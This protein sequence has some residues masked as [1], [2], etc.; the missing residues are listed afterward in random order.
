M[1]SG[2]GYDAMTVQVWTDNGDFP[3]GDSKAYTR[4]AQ[5]RSASTAPSTAPDSGGGGGGGGS[6]SLL[7]LL[8]LAL[9]AGRRFYQ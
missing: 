3:T 4:P 1:L 5:A 9:V 6:L 8:G 7:A 2:Q